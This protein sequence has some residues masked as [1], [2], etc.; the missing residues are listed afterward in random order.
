MDT[1]LDK[2]V[3]FDHQSSFLGCE[4]FTVHFRDQGNDQTQHDEVKS[5]HHADEQNECSCA[6]DRVSIVGEI[7]SHAVFSEYCEEEMCEREVSILP[8]T[9]TILLCTLPGHVVQSLSACVLSQS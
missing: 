4:Y 5:K 1:V 8:G 3:P 6:I 9:F 7:V 2:G